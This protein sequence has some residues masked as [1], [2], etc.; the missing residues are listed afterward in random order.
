MQK[1]YS[2]DAVDHKMKEP[3]K[4][5]IVLEKNTVVYEE[6]KRRNLMKSATVLSEFVLTKCRS[7][8]KGR[9]TKENDKFPSMYSM[10]TYGF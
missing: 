10:F 1:S 2:R 5:M 7:F 3:Q 8:L 6:A 4:W 9:I